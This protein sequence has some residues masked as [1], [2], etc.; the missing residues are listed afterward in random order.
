M[1]KKNAASLIDLHLRAM[2]VI[3]HPGYRPQDEIG[4]PRRSYAMPRAI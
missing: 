1:M 3:D 4:P 2:S